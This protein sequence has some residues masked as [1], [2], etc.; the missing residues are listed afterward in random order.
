MGRDQNNCHFC[1]Y[2]V[3]TSSPGWFAF[4]QGAPWHVSRFGHLSVQPR[5]GRGSAEGVEKVFIGIQPYYLADH[6]WTLLEVI[7]GC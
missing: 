1:R 5:H 2:F 7:D 6:V 3:R 4:L